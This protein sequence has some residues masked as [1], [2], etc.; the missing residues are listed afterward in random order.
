MRL[1]RLRHLPS[2]I[3]AGLPPQ[4]PADAL[5]QRMATIDTR[6]L[7]STFAGCSELPHIRSFSSEVDTG[8]REENAKEQKTRSVRLMQSGYYS[9]TI[10]SR[11]H[12][13]PIPPEPDRPAWPRPCPER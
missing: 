4:G 7:R 11:H 1:H 9:G 6:S 3:E 12:A 2:L 13:S 8:P 5:P 10:V